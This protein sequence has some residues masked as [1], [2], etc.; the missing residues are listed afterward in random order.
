[1]IDS[2]FV[3]PGA[4]A[5]CSDVVSGMS[6][7][8]VKGPDAP[9]WTIQESAPICFSVRSVSSLKLAARPDMRR[10]IANTSA[11]PVI[12][13]MNLRRRHCRSRRVACHIIAGSLA[14]PRP[15]REGSAG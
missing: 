6:A 14:L 2:A 3:T 13:I 9:A 11:V 7:S 5:T 12:A 15:P 4:A 1:M 8:D 10:L